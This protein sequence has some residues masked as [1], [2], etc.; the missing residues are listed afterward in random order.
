MKR[1][2]SIIATLLLLILTTCLFFTGC[3]E[4]V[5]EFGAW[6]S[7]NDQTHSRVCAKNSEHVETENHSYENGVCVCGKEEDSGVDPYV[8]TEAQWE[9]AI[10]LSGATKFKGDLVEIVEGEEFTAK[11]Y[12]DG[13]KLKVN[14]GVSEDIY[15]FDVTS[16][17]YYAYHMEGNG[18]FRMSG[19]IKS[20]WWQRLADMEFSQFTY[21]A[22]E[23]S[24]SCTI[25][26]ETFTVKFE[27]GEMIYYSEKDLKEDYFSGI[28]FGG[29]STEAINVPTEYVDLG[30]GGDFGNEEWAALFE[31]KNATVNITKITHVDGQP[32]TT[33][34]KA[35]IFSGDTWLSVSNTDTVYYDGTNYYL[36]GEKNSSDVSHYSYMDFE[37]FADYSNDFTQ[38]ENGYFA[39]SIAGMFYE[40]YED[41]SI[42]I[43]SEGKI[44]SVLYKEI[45]SYDFDGQTTTFVDT[46]TVS[47]DYENYVIENPDQYT[48]PSAWRSMFNLNK[49]KIQETTS[50]STST[51][52]VDGVKW[53]E[54]SSNEFTY[55]DGVYLYYSDGEE[56]SCVGI[57]S[58]DSLFGVFK[59]FGNSESLF[60]ESPI[61]TFTAE[62]TNGDYSTYYNVVVKVAQDKITEISYE[63]EY[64][65]N[66]TYTFTYNVSIDQN[67]INEK[68]QVFDNDQW[69]SKFIPK[70]VTIKQVLTFS[71]GGAQAS[72]GYDE[73]KIDN[74]TW[75]NE[76]YSPSSGGNGYEVDLS[77]A[78]D[79][80]K[81]YDNNV[82]TTEDLSD[83]ILRFTENMATFS[84]YKDSFT[85]TES[86]GVTTYTA[87]R[88]T[89]FETTFYKNIVIKVENNLITEISYDYGAIVPG[90][91]GNEDN[92]QE[93]FLLTFSNYGTTTISGIAK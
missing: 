29:E 55:F 5:H 63:S 3:D 51:Y 58:K 6:T 86:G 12:V 11:I 31:I 67:T 73:F 83:I 80:E 88:I 26:N 20:I 74:G 43:N 50:F 21:N 13:A 34:T 38:T 27:N 70:N 85:S 76:L 61:G 92:V 81:Y 82:E 16:G 78:F 23:K 87:E 18:W 60:V 35:L 37:D 15:D 77:Y 84:D 40:S 14:Y 19:T 90:A 75:S 33:S 54:E 52:T 89:L 53:L 65:I 9:N 24:Y 22:E 46:Y 44:S 25:E 1:I 66:Y 4:H 45:S 69:I 59:T 47:I 36:N 41:V 56:I 39:E 49:V 79:G 71:Q 64:G 48:Q 72:F 28:T 91:N 42:V 8:I 10:T 62:E 2:T 7:D 93:S 68:L 17:K 32:D 30:D 57:T